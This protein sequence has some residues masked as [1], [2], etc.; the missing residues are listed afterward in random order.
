M[1]QYVPYIQTFTFRTFKHE[2]EHFHVQSHKLADRIESSKEPE[3]ASSTSGVSE[4]AACLPSAIAEY[5]LAFISHPFS[6]FQS[7]TRPACSL[8]ASPC[9]PAVILYYCTFQGMV[10]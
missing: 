6:L 10:P 2:N 4:N 7:L 8:D 3:A 9:M 5:P 1:I